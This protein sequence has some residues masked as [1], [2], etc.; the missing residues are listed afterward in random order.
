[1]FNK[2]ILLQHTSAVIGCS[3]IA[4]NIILGTYITGAQID[5]L[6]DHSY[7][8]DR[9]KKRSRSQTS[10][11]FLTDATDVVTLFKHAEEGTIRIVRDEY[12]NAYVLH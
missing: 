11:F 6:K 3:Q 2:E 5:T 9:E 4:K 8:E 12:V 7:R 1:M 10:Q